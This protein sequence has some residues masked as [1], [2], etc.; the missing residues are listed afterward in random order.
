[1]EGEREPQADSLLSRDH[2][3]SAPSVGLYPMVQ[4]MT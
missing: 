1:M 4:I 3:P 2:P